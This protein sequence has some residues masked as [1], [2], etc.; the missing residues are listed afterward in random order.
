MAVD[1]DLNLLID[2]EALL[3]ALERNAVGVF[4]ADGLPDNWDA[5]A[6]A[7]IDQLKLDARADRDR[8]RRRLIGMYHAALAAGSERD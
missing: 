2:F 5:E 6:Q 7:D 3:D 8:V 1:R 4:E